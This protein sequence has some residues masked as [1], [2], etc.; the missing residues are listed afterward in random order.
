MARDPPIPLNP[1]DRALLKPISAL[2]K[3]AALA[4][5]VSFLRRTEYI[6]S[7]QGRHK[8]E[9]STSKDLLRIRND[10]KRKRRPNLDKE[11]PLNILRHVLKGFDIAYPQD[12]FAGEESEKNV[13][14]ADVVEA[15]T[16]AWAKPKHPTKPDVQLLDSY[17]VLPDL[18]AVPGV[19]SYII[20]KFNTNPLNN[21]DRSDRR[22]DVAV[23]RPQNAYEDKQEERLAAYEDDLNM[24][25]PTQEY[26][27]E[28]YVS[29]KP[30]AVRGMKRKF[31]VGDPDRDEPD[32]YDFEDAEGNKAFRFNRLREYETYQQAGDLDNAYGDTVALALHDPDLA[33]GDAED[34]TKRLRKGAYFYP[35]LQRTNLRPK[36]RAAHSQYSQQEVIDGLQITI[37]DADEEELARRQAE[38]AKLDPTVAVPAEENGLDGEDGAVAA[39]A[40]S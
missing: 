39:V 16:R 36:R 24:T 34:R 35:V 8:Y 32:L 37:R 29:E 27:Y 33:V 21:S 18:E 38:R 13:R 2:G 19:G 15:E 20:T 3:S 26:D 1:H 7:D 12:A 5:G 4:G 14:G 30:S 22:L 10:G 6:S 11:D 17:P 28:L 9:S 25:K 40:A 23:L 31:D